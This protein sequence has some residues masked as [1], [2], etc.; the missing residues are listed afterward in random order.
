MSKMKYT[1]SWSVLL[2]SRE[3]VTDG[4]MFLTGGDTS[5]QSRAS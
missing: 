4:V 2:S 5:Y 1:S 3:P